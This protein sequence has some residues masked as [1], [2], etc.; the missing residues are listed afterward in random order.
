MKYSN[1]AVTYCK[2]CKLKL[3]CKCST[4]ASFVT[5]ITSLL[6]QTFGAMLSCQLRVSEHY[7]GTGESFLFKFKPNEAE[8]TSELKVID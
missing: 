4:H 1:R 8:G 5:K 6:L 3:L 2:C 7:Y